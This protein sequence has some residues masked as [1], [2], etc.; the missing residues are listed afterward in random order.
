MNFFIF[1]Y[2]YSLIRLL[3]H[4]M[5]FLFM[6]VY[7]FHLCHFLSITH[8]LKKVFVG[9]N[10]RKYYKFLPPRMEVDLVI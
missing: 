5:A 9:E 1:K 10:S 7:S 2:S 3:N 6:C 8:Y 4:K